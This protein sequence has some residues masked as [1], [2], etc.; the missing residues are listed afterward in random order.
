LFD[1]NNDIPEL[2]GE[3]I[4][5]EGKK[6]FVVYTKP[7]REKKLAEFA[8]KN[9]IDYY[10]PLMDSVKYYDRKKLV[11]KKPMFSSYIFIRVTPKERRDIAVSG[12]TVSFII[13]SDEQQFLEE[14]KQ[15][16]QVRVT[17]VEATDH[18][19]ISEGT[20]VR[21]TE[22]SLEGI[23][24]LVTDVKNIDKVILQVNILKRAIA[25]TA[26]SSLLEVLE[27]EFNED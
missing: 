19:Y 20:R 15:I 6:W 7:R 8:L 13:V 5:V 26:D 11:Y 21:F 27:E 23:V 3:L 4:S 17:G 22:G 14:L 25:V 18:K 2:S 1:K 9:D 24:G 12:H 10:L 16:H